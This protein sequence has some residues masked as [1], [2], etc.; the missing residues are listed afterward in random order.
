MPDR[1]SKRGRTKL[2]LMGTPGDFTEADTQSGGDGPLC[3]PLFQHANQLPAQGDL[4]PFT[5]RQYGL[6][7]IKHFIRIQLGENGG[8]FPEYTI[9][10]MSRFSHKAKRAEALRIRSDLELI[11]QVTTK[12]NVSKIKFAQG[13][14]VLKD[15]I[16]V[17]LETEAFP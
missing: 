16:S 3:G 1:F 15:I 10:L 8:Q 11:A 7:H 2:Q 9:R 17:G 13:T 14:P 12:L 5:G 4:R 6:K